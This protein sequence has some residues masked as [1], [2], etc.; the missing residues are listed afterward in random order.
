MARNRDKRAAND[1]RAGTVRLAG[2]VSILLASA[3]GYWVNPFGSP[4]TSA[5]ILGGV[6]ALSFAVRGLLSRKK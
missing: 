1:N 6:A 4:Y 2:A 5:G 3:L